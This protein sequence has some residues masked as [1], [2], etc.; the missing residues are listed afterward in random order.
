MKRRT[1]AGDS[2][3]ALI[4]TVM[5]LTGELRQHGR[6]ITEPVGQSPA[7]W[8]V[9]GAVRETSLTVSQIARRMGSTRQ[10]IQRVA[11]V[12][13]QEGLI[14]FLDNRDHKSSPKVSLTD[15]GRRASRRIAD[16]QAVWANAI[17]EE[18]SEQS[19]GEAVKTLDHFLSVLR[20]LEDDA[21]A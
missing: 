2:A 13:A 10:G 6:R 21:F 15:S 19:V 17:G 1:P 20:G 3:T 9:L 5:E 12:L 16:R 18:V 11:N 8:Q 14:E 7:R 4:L